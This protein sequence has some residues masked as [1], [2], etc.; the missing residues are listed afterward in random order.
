M[1]VVNR[2]FNNA[3]ALVTGAVSGIGLAT[4]RAFA[5]AGAALAL[6]DV[7]ED[8]VRSAAEDRVAAGRNAIGIRC[9]VAEEAQV[10]AM[11]ERTVATFG[12]WT[13][14]STMPACRA[15]SLRPLTPTLRTTTS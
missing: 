1:R 6:V 4:A 8:A 11:V 10:A 9:N 5:D 12:G 15:R 7:R 2:S 3:V 14:R 13:R